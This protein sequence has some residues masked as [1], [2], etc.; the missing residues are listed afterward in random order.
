MLLSESLCRSQLVFY[1]TT[2][3]RF[4]NLAAQLTPD[5]VFVNLK[6]GVSSFINT[7]WE[8]LLYL[9]RARQLA[10]SYAPALQA[11]HL[12]YRDLGQIEVA[13][14]WLNAARN[15]S[16]Q[17]PNSLDWQWTELATDNQLTYIPFESTLLMAVEPSFHSIVTS[18]LLAEGDWFEKEMEFWRSWIQPGMT[19]MDIGANVGVYTFSAAQ[20][21]GPQGQVLA[22]EPFSGCVRCLE[23]TR[24]INQFSWVKVCAGAAS[25]RNGTVRL[26]LHAASKLNEV[27]SENAVETMAPES[28]EEVACFTLDSLCDRENLSQVDF[29]KI[30]AEGHEISVL[31]GS[32]RI[33]TQFSP[34]ILYEN[35]AGNQ[36]SNL[37]VADFLRARGYRLFRYQPYVQQLNPINSAEDLQ[38]TLNVIALPQSKV[39]PLNSSS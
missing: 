34:T 5:S 39:F 11:L 23:E 35:I 19:V 17:N 1:S 16:Q 25:D 4:L 7:H 32:E 37:P 36:G 18:V 24:R 27:V 10:P 6:L 13:D 15:Q 38:E 21:V 28:F 12:A 3:F 20:Q 9:H 26:S 31:A 33:L 14:F 30:D 8:G 22:V 2:G 29:L